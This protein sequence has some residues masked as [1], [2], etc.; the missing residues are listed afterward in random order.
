MN[1]LP[2]G[3]RVVLKG[4]SRHSI[5]TVN[6]VKQMKEFTNT[7]VFN[8][9]FFNLGAKYQKSTIQGVYYIISKKSKKD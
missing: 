1:N 6:G 5:E 2:P 3:V 4:Y 7:R 9:R 8:V